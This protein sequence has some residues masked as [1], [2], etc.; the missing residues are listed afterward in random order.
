MK[1]ALDSAAGGARRIASLWFLSLATDRLERAQPALADRPLATYAESH[2]ALLL[3]G[4]NRAAH[5]AGL[6]PG[7][8]LANARAIE[9]DVVLKRAEPEADAALLRKL[10]DWC[11]RYTPWAAL[12]GPDGLFLDV[13]GCAHLFAA[14]GGSDNS[15]EEALLQDMVE[16]LNELGFSLRLA[17]ADTPLAAAALARFGP[18]PAIVQTEPLRRALAELPVQALRIQAGPA[19]DLRRVGL[20]LIGDILPLPRASLAARFGFDLAQRLDRALGDLADPISPDPFSA[21]YR[22]RL[23]FPDPIGLPEDIARAVDRLLAR[24]TARLER[25]GKGCRKLELQAFRADGDMRRLTVG[26]ARAARDPKHLARLFA[27][28]LAGLDPGFGIDAMVLSAPAVEDLAPVQEQA[29]LKTD[30]QEGD[31]V[32]DPRLSLLADQLAA[33]L[34]PRRVL[35]FTARD[36]HCPERA[37][38]LYPVME[39]DASSHAAPAWPAWLPPRPPLLLA[40]PEP[41]EVEGGSVPQGFRWRG[42]SHI[43]RRL[44]GPE[45]LSPEWWLLKDRGQDAPSAMS[46]R[47]YYRVEDQEGRRFWLYRETPATARPGGFFGGGDAAWRL[48]GLFQ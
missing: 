23:N 36:S 24:M 9:P 17:L 13:T 42:R 44:E 46:A 7:M 4:V 35:R 10:R 18:D 37:C 30:A 28:R 20:R 1:A 38:R 25:D 31:P 33:R 26:A 15:D 12:D 40:P 41:L 22:V 5:L 27:E 47:D 48:H 32:G 14:P 2:N 3:T 16:R 19:E 21:P 43:I 29:A 45:R 11:L 39:A 34:G 8:S 6:T